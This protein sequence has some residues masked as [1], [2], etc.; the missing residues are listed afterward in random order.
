MGVRHG[1]TPMTEENGIDSVPLRIS[2][3]VGK[4]KYRSN[5]ILQHQ[6]NKRYK[7]SEKITARLES[8][9]LIYCSKLLKNYI[10]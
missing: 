1:K 6:D 8:P 9:E 7:N 10:S 4:F 3:L 2:E 5:S